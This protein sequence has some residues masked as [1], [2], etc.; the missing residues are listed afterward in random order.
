VESPTRLR[1]DVR[2]EFQTEYVAR[3]SRRMPAFRFSI[4]RR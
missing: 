2:C 1:I 3:G 4:P